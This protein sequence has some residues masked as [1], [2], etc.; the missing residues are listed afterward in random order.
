MKLIKYIFIGLAF[1]F[2]CTTFFMCLAIGFNDL[3]TQILAWML[4]SCFYGGVSMIFENE[5]LSMLT[6]NIIHYG[7]CSLVTLVVMMLFYKEIMLAVFLSFT[8]TYIIIN[9]LVTYY[10]NKDI[11]KLNEKLKSK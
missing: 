10:I 2:I 6:K 7:V 8:I 4:A 3:T 9:I 1:G 5:S 11:Q